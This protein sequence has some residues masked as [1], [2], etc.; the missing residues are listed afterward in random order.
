MDR[1]HVQ[2]NKPEV[3][4]YNFTNCYHKF[5]QNSAGSCS[6]QSWTVDVKLSL[7]L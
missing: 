2:K 6:S 4:R 1:Q 3:F 5:P 7:H